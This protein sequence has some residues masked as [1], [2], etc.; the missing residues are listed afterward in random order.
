MRWGIPADKVLFYARRGSDY[1]AL[2]GQFRAVLGSDHSLE[3]KSTTSLPRVYLASNPN[4]AGLVEG[5]HAY[6]FGGGIKVPA[7][8]QG[9]EHD[10]VE[11]QEAVLS[12]DMQVHLSDGD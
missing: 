8:A 10:D 9:L 2:S 11:E 6:Q 12:P 3:L 7:S 5:I 1:E 4:F